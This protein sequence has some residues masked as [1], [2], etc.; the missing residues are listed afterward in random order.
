MYNILIFGD[1]IAAGRK[2]NKIDSWP[3]LLVQFLDKKDRDFTLVH[4]LGIS[5]DSSKEVVERFSVE[6]ESRCKR[7]YSN[8][9]CSIIFAIGINDAKRVGFKNRCFTSKEKFRNNVNLLI[10]NAKKYTHH[11]IFVGLTPVDEQKTMIL[12]N[13]YF[14]NKDIE[15]YEKIIGEEC[16]K[17]N[18]IFVS[19]FEEWLKLDYLG[20]LSDDGIH[21]NKR[22]H[23]KIFKKIKPFFE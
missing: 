10:K 23:Q 13:V 1:S 8:D 4:N 22:G 6:A 5:G 11:I 12:G 14:F 3:F 15:V 20:L 17:R 21:P 18:I 9:R 19:I 7:I 2:V 16:K